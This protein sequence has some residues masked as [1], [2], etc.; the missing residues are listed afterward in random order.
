[1]LDFIGSLGVIGY[2]VVIVLALC[3]WNI[4]KLFKLRTPLDSIQHKMWRN[5]GGAGGA[6]HL[7]NGNDKTGPNA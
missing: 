4:R 1:M 7:E 6:D 5:T 2:F 3:I